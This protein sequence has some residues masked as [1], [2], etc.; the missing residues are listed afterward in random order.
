VKYDYVYETKDYIDLITEHALTP[1]L[2][3]TQIC[4]KKSLLIGIIYFLY[5]WVRVYENARETP[6]SVRNSFEVNI[7]YY[8]RDFF[9]SFSLKT[10]KIIYYN[11]KN[12]I[13]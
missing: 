1:K 13:N 5:I 9:L 10:K 4:F 2:F 3:L 11:T 7:N 8:Y 6:E 12:I